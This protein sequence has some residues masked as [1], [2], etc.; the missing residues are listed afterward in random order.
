MRS[1]KHGVYGCIFMFLE[2]L[3]GGN[4]RGREEDLDLAFDMTQHNLSLSYVII[5]M[6][7]S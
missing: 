1:E 5:I 3:K 6:C 7:V 4:S 2:F